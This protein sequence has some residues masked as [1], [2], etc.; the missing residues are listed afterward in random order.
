M[1]ILLRFGQSE[2]SENRNFRKTGTFGKSKF[3]TFRRPLENSK[4]HEKDPLEELYR[5]PDPTLAD[6]QNYNVNKF[7]K[8]LLGCQIEDIDYYYRNKK[9][10]MSH[11]YSEQYRVKI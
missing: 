8:E 2:L 10:N 7:P 3:S 11:L 1:P 9:V 6:G 4:N 5:K